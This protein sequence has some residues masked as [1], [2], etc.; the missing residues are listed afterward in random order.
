M[1]RQDTGSNAK[2]LTLSDRNLETILKEVRKI[3]SVTASKR[4]RHKMAAFFLASSHATALQ[5]CSDELAWAMREFEVSMTTLR[6]LLPSPLTISSSRT[7]S[8]VA[9]STPSGYVTLLTKSPQS[10]ATSKPS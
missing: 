5:K 10:L 8:L 4:K 6:F 3:E 9:S 7:R 1:S 2:P